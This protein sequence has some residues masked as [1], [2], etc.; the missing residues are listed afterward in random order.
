VTREGIGGGVVSEVRE[1]VGELAFGPFRLS[2]SRRLLFRVT[3]QGE[4]PVSLGSRALDLLFQ[5]RQSCCKHFT[6]MWQS[7]ARCG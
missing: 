6:R 7:R 3:D 1:P 5:E 2:V 4:E